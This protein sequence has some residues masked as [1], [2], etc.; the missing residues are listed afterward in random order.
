V[1]ELDIAGA[2]LITAFLVWNQMRSRPIVPQ[3]LALIPVLL[4]IL[5]LI[6]PG[7]VLPGTALGVGLLVLGLVLALGFGVARGRAAK[8]WLGPGAQFWRS[9][10]RW[11]LALW[12]ASILVKVGLDLG[13]SQVG[14]P[15]PGGDLF[16][17]LGVSLAAQN[18]VLLLR[19]DGLTSLLGPPQSRRP[20]L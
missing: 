1:N 5:G 11:L 20:S 10:S 6:Q 13:G 15:I 16:L 8:V 19:S 2:L 14:A 9:G 17:E 4:V 7:S 18:A 12:V 3:R